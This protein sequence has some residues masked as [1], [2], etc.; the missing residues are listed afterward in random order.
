MQFEYQT[1][2]GVKWKKLQ[3]TLNELGRAG[4]ETVMVREDVL[5]G[6]SMGVFSVLLK[7]LVQPTMYTAS[8]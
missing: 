7:R 8:M 5:G 1:L 6:T 2:D 4:W 3:D